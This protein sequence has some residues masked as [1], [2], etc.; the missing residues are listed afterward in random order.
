MPSSDFRSVFMPYCLRREA[1]GRYLVLSRELAPL[2]RAEPVAF[3]G[4]TS[5][6]AA[7]VSCKGDPGLA[8]IYLYDDLAPPTSSTTAMKAYFGRVS[9]LMKLKVD[10]P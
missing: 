2:G 8:N 7:A 3:K 5:K 1:D 4:L 6:I 10:A 9:R